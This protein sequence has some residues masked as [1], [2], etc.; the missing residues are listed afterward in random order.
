M[1]DSTKPVINLKAEDFE[2]GML[3]LR[4]GEA[5]TP[6]TIEPRIVDI[7]GIHTAPGIFWQNRGVKMAQF[8]PE[9]CYVTYNYMD[10]MIR[11]MCNETEPYFHQV[12]GYI[13][14]HPVWLQLG[15][16]QEKKY[17]QQS[18]LKELRFMQPYFVEEENYISLMTRLRN[19]HGTFTKV[20]QKSDDQK[21]NKKDFIERNLQL[22]ME[23]SFE[24]I[25]PIFLGVVETTVKVD[26]VAAY[27]VES[28]VFYLESMDL[29][30]QSEALTKKIFEEE[31]A[32]LSDLVCIETL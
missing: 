17:T 16:N 1:T 11:L 32:K 27:E 9:N 8:Q 29:I 3:T 31:L 18:L 2:D 10:K 25:C 23:W 28:L 5:A 20:I 7:T 4:V 12:L 6:K 22:E 19:V 24:L 13:K 15:V 14:D 30:Q 26:I 21:G